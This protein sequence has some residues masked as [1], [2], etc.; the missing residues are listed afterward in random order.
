VSTIT[1]PNATNPARAELAEAHLQRS[2]QGASTKPAPG[3]NKGSAQTDALKRATQIASQI[4]DP[5][6]PVVTLADLG[7]LRGVRAENGELIVTITPTYAGCPAMHQMKDDLRAALAAEA[8]QARIETVLSPAW[9]TD[10]ITQQGREKLR[11][12]GIAPPAARAHGDNVLHFH[13]PANHSP[14]CPHCGS[15]TTERLSQFGSTACKALY[16]C[17]A[18]KEPF[19]YFKPY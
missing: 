18:C 8:I 14:K 11:R 5:E 2:V 17:L 1:T 4:P 16:R 13:A 19:D 15:K 6:I 9:T 10:W 3:L 12:Y 7:I